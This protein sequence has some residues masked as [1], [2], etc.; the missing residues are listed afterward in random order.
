MST[1]I[2]IW[3][4]SKGGSRPYIHMLEFCDMYSEW[5]GNPSLPLISIFWR[6]LWRF[7]FIYY[8]LPLTYFLFKTFFDC[9][10]SGVKLRN[11]G[12]FRCLR[13]SNPNLYVFPS[14]SLNV[15]RTIGKSQVYVPWTENTPDRPV[16]PLYNK[17]GKDF[18]LFLRFQ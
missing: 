3:I 10:S 6:N 15:H 9:F 18:F 17:V 16:G 11:K 14:T 4:Y 7:I 2:S 5:E 12:T 1:N 8:Y 13:E